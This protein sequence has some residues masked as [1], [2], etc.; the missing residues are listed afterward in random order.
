MEAYTLE[1][2]NTGAPR[3][4]VT[5]RVHAGNFDQARDCMSC[6]MYWARDYY[7]RDKAEAKRKAA[8]LIRFLHDAGAD[9]RNRKQCDAVMMPKPVIVGTA[10]QIIG[11]LE[12]QIAAGE[13]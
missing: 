5:W 7:A 10:N 11:A 6:E 3:Y 13:P 2:Y 4:K 8:S 9:L 1:I 12:A